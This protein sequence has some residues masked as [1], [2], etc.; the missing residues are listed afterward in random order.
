MYQQAAKQGTITQPYVAEPTYVT[1]DASGGYT[2]TNIQASYTIAGTPQNVY[3]SVINVN[4]QWKLDET[5]GTVAV[6]NGPVK[7]FGGVDVTD[8]TQA[9]PG[10]Y[11]VSPPNNRMT[12]EETKITIEGPGRSDSFYA[13]AKLTDQGAKDFTDAAKAAVDKCLATNDPKPADCPWIS[14]NYSGGT[15]KPGS[16]R[17]KLNNNPLDGATARLST[18]TQAR[19]GMSVQFTGT[20]QSS[21]GAPLTLSST[22]KYLVAT[23]GYLEGADPDLVQLSDP[24]PPARTPRGGGAAAPPPRRFG[25]GTAQLQ[26]LVEPQPSQT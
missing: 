8:T 13:R 7:I 25:S 10:V 5:T 20:A 1:A 15:I 16:V 18:G 22:T 11:E 9:L 14:L 21:T 12:Y 2:K 3:F 26:P 6:S 17:L 24:D 4:G 19:I 23:G